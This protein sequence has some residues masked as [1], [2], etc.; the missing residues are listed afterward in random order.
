VTAIAA[1]A[2]AG[3]QATGNTPAGTAAGSTSPSASSSP[4]ATSAQPSESPSD[5]SAAVAL[6]DVCAM[7]SR[8][9]VSDLTGGKSIL[10]VDPDAG[11]GSPVRYCQWQLSGARLGVQLSATTAAQFRQD[12]PTEPA[13]GGLGDDAFFFSNHLFVRE[14]AIQIDVYASTAEGP[15]ND[16]RLAKAVAA[17]V[18]TRLGP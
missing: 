5:T 17:I 13:I 9:E 1:F 10:S 11:P 16:Q 6:P 4:P 2:L 3:C 14:G 7:F 12:H 15:A 18:V 8:A